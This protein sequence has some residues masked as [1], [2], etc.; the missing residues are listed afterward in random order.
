M[1]NFVILWT[2][3]LQASLSM[4][5]S[6]QEH[7]SELPCLP[8]GDL[9]NPGINLCLLRLLHWQAGSLPLVPSGKLKQR[10]LKKQ[11]SWNINSFITPG[12]GLIISQVGWSGKYFSGPRSNGEG[13]GN[14]LLYACLENPMDRGAWQAIQSI[15]LQW[16]GHDLATKW[17]PLP[18]SKPWPVSCPWASYGAPE[19]FRIQI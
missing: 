17:Q 7:W 6:R 15:G 11:R 14:P 13:N 8:P 5:F 4:G 12:Q 16:V 1:S 2:I 9:P 3:A 19:V 18:S 10:S